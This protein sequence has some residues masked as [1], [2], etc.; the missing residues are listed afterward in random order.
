MRF[1]IVRLRIPGMFKSV[2]WHDPERSEGRETNRP[3]LHTTYPI[4]T[5][6]RSFAKPPPS[7]HQ[8]N[9]A[10]HRG[11]LNERYS[12][13]ESILICSEALNNFYSKAAPARRRT[14][15]ENR[16]EKQPR[17]DTTSLHID[18]LLRVID[19]ANHVSA[20]AHACP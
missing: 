2:G 12:R 11:K 8:K 17:S 4:P 16:S 1:K 19:D 3:G 15:K 10:D 7:L 18:P 20:A 6:H 14:P 5:Y 9:T 13:S